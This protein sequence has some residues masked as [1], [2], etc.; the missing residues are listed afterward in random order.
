MRKHLRNWIYIMDFYDIVG[1]VAIG[2][3]LRRLNEK[4]AEDGAEIYKSYGIGVDPKWFPVFYALSIKK[5]ASIT[6]IASFIGHSHP[7]VSQIAKEMKKQGLLESRKSTSDKRVTSI[8]LSDKGQ[9]FIPQLE[10]QCED[11]KQAV[12]DILSTTQHNLWKAIEEFEFSLSEKK[13]SERVKALR[14]ERERQHVEIMDYS[15]EFKTDFQKLNENWIKKHF[16]MEDVDH[17]QL[18]DPENTIL[19]P[20]GHIIMARYRGQVVG[21]CALIKTEDTGYELAKMAVSESFKGLGIGTILGKSIIKKATALHAEHIF[22]E[23]N[24]ALKEAVQLYLKLGFKKISGPPS[25]YERCNIQ[26]KLDL[27]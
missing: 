8:K 23:S 9:E 5:E 7:S 14:K 1:K 19:K 22:L 18:D 20:G 27:V 21:T 2:S 4:I 26:M 17:Q 25:P 12:E 3:R 16:K 10:Q 11:V 6:E 13:L 15:P 24:T